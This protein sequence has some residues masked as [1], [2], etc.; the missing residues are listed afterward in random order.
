MRVGEGIASPRHGTK[1][2]VH[3][4][5]SCDETMINLVIS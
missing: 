5:V 3:S 1:V 2:G 4:W